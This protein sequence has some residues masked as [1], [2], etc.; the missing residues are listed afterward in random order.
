MECAG[1]GGGLSGEGGQY[2]RERGL[3]RDRGR[4]WDALPG[5]R[6]SAQYT[7]LAGLFRSISY[8]VSF[9]RFGCKLP[10]LVIVHGRLILMLLFCSI[11]NVCVGLQLFTYK[12]DVNTAPLAQ[13]FMFNFPA[14]KSPFLHRQLSTKAQ[15]DSMEKRRVRPL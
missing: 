2:Q 12:S 10:P 15:N 8:L 1:T 6:L 13:R 14:V 7:C 5:A 9:A 3:D 4:L 11:F